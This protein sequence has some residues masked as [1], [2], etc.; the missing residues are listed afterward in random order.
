MRFL[1]VTLNDFEWRNG[2]YITELEIF[3]G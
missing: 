1:L 3:W 2:R